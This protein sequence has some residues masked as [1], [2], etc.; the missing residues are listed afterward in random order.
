MVQGEFSRMLREL[1][2]LYDL[3]RAGRMAIKFIEDCPEQEFPYHD[4][5]REAVRSTFITI[6]EAV[7]Q[8]S[9]EF[10]VEHPEIP[11]QKIIG[12][13]NIIV[14]NYDGIDWERIYRFTKKDLPLVC[15]QIEALL[16]PAHDQQG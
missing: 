12:L 3:L 11:W 4:L 15:A 6:G 2:H 1:A 5:T 7:R 10:R 13:R 14:H 9:N 8:L 16:P